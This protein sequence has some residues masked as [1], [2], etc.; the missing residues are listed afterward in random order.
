MCPTI[1]SLVV[2][3]YK[4]MLLCFTHKAEEIGAIFNISNVTNATSSAVVSDNDKLTSLIHLPR[5]SSVK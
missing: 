4:D 3:Y 2:P 5:A 1:D